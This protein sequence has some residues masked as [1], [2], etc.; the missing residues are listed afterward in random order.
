MTK[1]DF[2]QNISSGEIVSRGLHK[3]AIAVYMK[4]VSGRANVRQLARRKKLTRAVILIKSLELLVNW[5]RKLSR[6]ADNGMST[7]CESGQEDG[8]QGF[9]L[10]LLNF[11]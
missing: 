8:C 11:I 6:S 2:F 10:D 5:V 3:N 4:A 7:F 9:R 1:I